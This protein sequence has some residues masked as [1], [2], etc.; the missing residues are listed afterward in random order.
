ME[1]FKGTI[2]TGDFDENTVTIQM[3]KPITLKAGEYFVIPKEKYKAPEMLEMLEELI[4]ANPMH[5]GWHEKIL[6]A[7]QLIKEAT[8]I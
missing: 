3:D 8:E 6:K 7:N 4:S 1:K 5:D 2:V